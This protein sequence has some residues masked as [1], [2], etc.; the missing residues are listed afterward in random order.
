[1]PPPQCW[2][3]NYPK[4]LSSPGFYG[5]YTPFSDSYLASPR[6]FGFLRDAREVFP[7]QLQLARIQPGDLAAV[8][9]RGEEGVAR[10]GPYRPFF[11][12]GAP[13]VGLPTA[14][15][16]HVQGG[17]VL[18]ERVEREGDEFLDAAGCADQ[19]EAFLEIGE[20]RRGLVPPSASRASSRATGAG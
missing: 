18:G 6:Q 7:D 13:G 1:M 9:D 12:K 16:H 4:T 2:L 20:P 11:E 15:V 17:E 8:P 10:F 3:S 19:S 14:P 5:G